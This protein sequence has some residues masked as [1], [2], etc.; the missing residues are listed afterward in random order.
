MQN[1]ALWSAISHEVRSGLLSQE[2]LDSLR[3]AVEQEKDIL[4][5][6]EANQLGLILADSSLS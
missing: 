1:A 2:A 5:A 6:E 4:T 3:R